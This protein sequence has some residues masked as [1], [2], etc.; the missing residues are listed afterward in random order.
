MAQVMITVIIP[1][2][3]EAATIAQKV[4]EVIGHPSV[5]EV[6]VV[7]DGSNDA[8]AALAKAAGARVI[9][10]AENGGKAGALD[11][12]VAAS[13]E[14]ILLF[15]D[16]DV[17]GYTHAMLSRIIDPVVS[18]RYEMF[19]GIRA[20]RTIWL[21][22]ILH[23]FPILG[24]ERALTRALWQSIPHDHKQGFKIEI[25]MNYGAKW[26]GKGMGFALIPGTNHRIKEKKYGLLVGLI[27][28]IDM[29]RQVIVISFRLY[30]IGYVVRLAR[31]MQ[32]RLRSKRTKPGPESLH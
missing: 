1:A 21:N 10:H 26:T 17:T 9:R 13:S 6:I 3:D 32:D 14:K 5:R 16:A 28:R 11:A 7:D 23:F 8:T 22:R 24:G 15:L 18:G 2:F 12:G 27:R 19:V 30:I 25:A 4:A 20:R 29:F 31:K